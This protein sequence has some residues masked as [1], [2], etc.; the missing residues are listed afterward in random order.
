MNPH[1]TTTR[2]GAF[3]H[4]PWDLIPVLM[5]LGHLAFVAFLFFG[6]HATPWAIWIP[7][8]L[9]YS[10]SISWSI[11]SVSHNFIHNAFFVSP[12]LNRIYSFVLSLSDGFSQEFYHHVHL[13]HH[14]GN[15]DRI[16][17]NGTTIDPLSIYRRGKNGKP[18]SPWTYTF[19]SYFRDDIG[20]CYTRLKEKHPRLARWIRIE[21]ATV[22]IIYL[23]CLIYDWRAFL[24]LVPF[25]YFGHSLSSLNGYYEHFKGDP[26][27][28][29]AWGVST[30]NKLYNW[31]WLYNGFHAEHHYRPKV[32]WTRMIELRDRIRDEQTAKGVH[33]M[34]WC[35]ALGFLDHAPPQYTLT[36]NRQPTGAV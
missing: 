13:R 16:G 11:N 1:A 26:D 14:V 4:T 31:T 23:A 8:A 7:L 33:V 20:E 25:Y 9:V 22:V 15:M 21:I 24:A 3:A 36:G 17:A 34:G 12:A 29:I 30:Y 2:R 18:E 10:I 6:F 32:H 5:G 19:Y 35:H 27:T 28:P